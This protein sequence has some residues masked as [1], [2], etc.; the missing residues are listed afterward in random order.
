MVTATT[1]TLRVASSS[2]TSADRNEI[3]RVCM[4]SV[5]CRAS[6]RR[7]PSACALARPKTCKVGRPA[8]RSAKWLANRVWTAQR[9]LVTA[10]VVQPTRIMNT[11][12]NGKVIAKMIADV[13]SALRIAADTITGTVTARSN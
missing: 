6:V 13:R 1:A 11:G 8:I 4:V 3:R 10:S 12:I 9:R 7:S 2:S 5:R